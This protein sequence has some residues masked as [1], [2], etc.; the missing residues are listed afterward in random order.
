MF[1]S[2][3]MAN[4]HGDVVTRYLQAVR[5]AMAYIHEAFADEHDRRRDGPA[6]T[7]IVAIIAK[8]LEQPPDLIKR[9]FPFFDPQ[10]RIVAQNFADLGAWYK[11]QGMLKGELDVKALIDTRYELLFSEHA[12][13]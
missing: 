1:T 9:G 4:E 3:A 13:Q 10:A 11:A 5:N 2:T 12:T 7:E 8:Y 6:A